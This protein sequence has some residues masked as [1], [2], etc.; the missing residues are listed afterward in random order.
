MSNAQRKGKRNSSKLYAE[1][2]NRAKNKAQRIAKDARRA[3]P[4]SCGHGSRYRWESPDG[5]QYCACCGE[6]VS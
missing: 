1:R 2:G 3:K 5:N 4:M 6:A